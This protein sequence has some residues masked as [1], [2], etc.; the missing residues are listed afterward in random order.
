MVRLTDVVGTHFFFVFSPPSLRFSTGAF[1]MEAKRIQT[2]NTMKRK[3]K[4]RRRMSWI[5]WEKGGTADGGVMEI[6]NNNKQVSGGMTSWA[7]MTHRKDSGERIARDNVQ[8]PLREL[9]SLLV[10]RK[11][12]EEVA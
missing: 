5:E 6:K 1:V 7:T 4:W 9:D 2:T 8:H 10:D 12:L 3:L 11:N